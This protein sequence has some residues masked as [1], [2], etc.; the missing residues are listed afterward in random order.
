MV[1]W[2][3]AV[4]A[5][6]KNVVRVSTLGDGYGS[7]VIVPPPK[8]TSGNCCVLTAYHVIQRAQETGATIEIELAKSGEKISLPSLVRTIFPARDRDQ[9]IILFNGPPQ[10]GTPTGYKFLSVNRHYVPGVEFGWLGYPALEIAK[11][12]VCFLHGKISAYLENI[13][14]YLVDGSSIHGVSGGPVFC[15][16]EDEVV[17]A[18]IVT[19]YFPNQIAIQSSGTQIWPGLAMFRTINPLMKLYAQENKKNPDP[20]PQ[21]AATSGK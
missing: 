7:G 10:F 18:G 14:A 1:K 21:I 9:A 6:M 17:L 16:E 12:T 15:C 20:L 4:T 13:E 8:H 2:H 3:Q 11:D 5:M 19:N